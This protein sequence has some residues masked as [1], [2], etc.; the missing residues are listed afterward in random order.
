MT[1]MCINSNG[2]FIAFLT[3][4]MSADK[5]EG[6]IRDRHWLALVPIQT[7]LGGASCWDEKAAENA[8]ISQYTG[9][10]DTNGGQLEE[11]PRSARSDAASRSRCV[12]LGRA[13]LR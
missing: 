3:T 4:G 7:F 1:P 10:A 13:A 8:M 5:S 11:R 9:P 2:I 6:R 12:T